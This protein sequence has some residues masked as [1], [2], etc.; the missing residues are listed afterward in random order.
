MHSDRI[1]HKNES[2]VEILVVLLHIIFVELVGLL[3][4][5]GEEVNAG[6]T[7][8]QWLKELLE[9]RMEAYR[10]SDIP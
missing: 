6:V 2:R 5:D 9:G 7:C 10:K 3:A 4:I 8:P 1:T